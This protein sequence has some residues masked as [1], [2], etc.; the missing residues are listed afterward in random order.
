MDEPKRITTEEM[1]KLLENEPGMSPA[2]RQALIEGQCPYDDGRGNFVQA[3]PTFT[4]G[5]RPTHHMYAAVDPVETYG[6]DKCKL[7]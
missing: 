7:S 5:A 6:A 2:T 3:P 4:D 1:R